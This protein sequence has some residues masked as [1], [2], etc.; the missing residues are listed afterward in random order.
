M[1]SK[2]IKILLADD[3]A[4]MR[5]LL[6][7]RLRAWGFDVFLASDG[8]EARDLVESCDPD[9]VLTDVLMPRLTGLDLLHCLKAGNPDRPILLFTVQA[10]IDMAVEAMKQGAQDFLT[11]P[12]DFGKL[13]ASLDAILRDVKSKEDSK[14]L[15]AHLEEGAGF[16][17]FVGTSKVMRELYSMLQSVSL[18][19]TSVLISGESGTGKELAARSIHALSP[20]ANR[21]FIAVNT[22]A[23]PETLIESEL[24]GHEKGAFTGAIDMRE[25]CFEMADQGILFLDEIAEMPLH[26][27]PRLL[28]VLQDGRVRRVGGQKEFTFNVRVIAATNMD[29]RSAIEKGKLREDLYYRLNVFGLRLPSL[30]ERK[31]DIPLLAQYFIRESNQK[32]HTKVEAL[33]EGALKQLMSYNWP[34]NVREMRNVMERAVILAR[35]HWIEISDLPAYLQVGGATMPITPASLTAAEAEKELILKT[36][37]SAGNKKSEAA[38]R[39]GLDVKTIRNKL[40]SYGIGPGSS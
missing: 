17:G 10:S 5:E 13:K 36:L 35:S 37:K 31:D 38:R 21:P 22:A 18:N 27:Q 11:K 1:T 28:R 20:R 40:K 6:G 7:I 24:F 34:G 15:A 8:V 2:P 3:D 32:H 19:N 4:D 16:G 26:L 12:L 33:R 39:L 9:V 23:I 25:G 30:R 14:R 29:I